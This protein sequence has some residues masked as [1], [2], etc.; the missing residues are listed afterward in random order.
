RQR[1]VKMSVLRFLLCVSL[2]PSFSHGR[3]VGKDEAG[4]A[5][6]NS[7]FPGRIP[8]EGFTEPFHV[9]ICQRY[10]GEPRFATLYSTRDKIP[11][12]SAFKYAGSA[13]SGAAESWLLEPQIDDPENEQHEMVLEA[14]A[15]GTLANL[16][17]NQALTSDYVG[18]GYERGLLNPSSLNKEDFQMATYTL[19]N[20]VPLQPSLS[21][22]WHSDVGRVVEQALVPHCSKKDQLYLLAGAVPSS[23]RVKGK[24]SVP[25]SLW[26]AAC[27]DAP[28]G[29]S[30]GLVKKGND[31]SSLTDLT[32][33]ELEKQL[34]GGLDLFK[35][36][37]GEDNKG[38][39]KM[40]AVLQAVS[41]IRSGEQVG[42]NDQE[43][44]DSGLVRKVVGIIATPFIK[45]LELLIYLLVELVKFTFYF[46]W[47]VIKRIGNTVLGGVYSLWNGTVSYLKA[48]SM[49][50]ISIPYDVGRVITNI[51]L[52]FLGIIRDVAVITYRIL[53]IPMGFVL[54]L[55]S[56]PYYSICAIPSVVKDMAT[57]IGGTFSLAID[58]TASIL[59]GFYYVAS[60][61]AK[62]FVPK[63]S[64]GD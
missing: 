26:L 15:V 18:S 39:E 47:L 55:A 21:K 24:V 3:V 6:C 22:T 44:T 5:E 32:V 2:F 40:E 1:T 19:T 16:G 59:H 42:T 23:V 56:F 38:N 17:A 64:S 9:K 61:I 11:L 36:S 31:E 51:F 46:L 13:R 35:G 10:N 37:C 48:I 25:E 7:F 34:L 53:R 12:Y 29:W 8:P 49:V 45:L 60:H 43:A 63:G 28:E 57:G 30:L 41:R 27:C 54:H 4:F 33:G 50:L 58:A 20:A 14:D 52:G 62:R